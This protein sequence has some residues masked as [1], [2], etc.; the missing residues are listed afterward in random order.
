VDEEQ[1]VVGHQSSPTQ[2][3]DGEEVR[4]HKDIHMGADEVF[5]VLVW[6]RLGA[7]AIP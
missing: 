6:R 3:F 2:H 5:Q 4:A 7:G 1:D